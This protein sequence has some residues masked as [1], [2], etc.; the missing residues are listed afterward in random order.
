[1]EFWFRGGGGATTASTAKLLYSSGFR[2]LVSR[3][4]GSVLQIDEDTHMICKF[5]RKAKSIALPQSST[6]AKRWLPLPAPLPHWATV[7]EVKPSYYDETLLFT[8]YP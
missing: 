7:K 1:M 2:A 3:R 6:P 8:I 4:E 5:E